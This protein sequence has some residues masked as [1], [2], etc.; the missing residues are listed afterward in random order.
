M[1]RTIL[2]LILMFTISLATGGNDIWQN[3][4]KEKLQEAKEGNSSAQFD[5]AGMYQNG[6]GVKPDLA[7]AVE[8]YKKSAAQNYSKAVTRLKLLEANEGRFKKVLAKAEKGNAESQ[9]KLGKMYAEGVGVSMDNAKSTQAFESAAE[10]GHAKAEYNLGLRHYEG[11]GVKRNRT[12]AYKW[13]K[14]AADQNDPA[15]QYYLGKMFASGSGVKQNY[16]TSLEW[17]TKSV[18]GGFN[19]ARGEMIDVSERMKMQKAEKAK[20]AP[21]KKVAVK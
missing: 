5:V 18:D 4:F 1:K 15:A 19:Q 10:Q 6:R 8:W 11:I 2:T 17:F 14:A 20:P 13:F 12:T 21:V 3:L 16:T 9:Y 7:K